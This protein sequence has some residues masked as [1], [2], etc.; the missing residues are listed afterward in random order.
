LST[1]RPDPKLIFDTLLARRE[2][3]EAHPNKISSMLFALASIIIHD[4]VRTRDRD[5][6]VVN[7]SSYLDL[8]PLYGSDQSGQD[9]MRTFSDGRLKPDAFA[10]VRFVNQ[11]PEVRSVIERRIR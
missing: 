4:V 9:G 3:P 7:T 8:S 11:P 6:S 10:E 5:S 1:S 2:V